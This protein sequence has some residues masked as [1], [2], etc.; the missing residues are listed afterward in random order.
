MSKVAPSV[1]VD[2][3]AKETALQS[4]DTMCSI[5]L[6][7]NELLQLNANDCSKDFRLPE[8]QMSGISAHPLISQKK[9]F[10][11][12]YA[13]L[14]YS[15]FTI[16]LIICLYYSFLKDYQSINSFVEPKSNI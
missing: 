13:L 12:V 4:E 16:G 11:L 7:N 15:N 3:K 14:K 6:E 8:S 2:S 1:T 5:N 9:G 10:P